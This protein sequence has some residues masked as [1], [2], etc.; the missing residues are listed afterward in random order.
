M[1]TM[2]HNHL[3]CWNDIPE[4]VLINILK[5]LD[6]K[7][8]V[9]CSEVCSDWNRVCEDQLL[10][11][12]LFTRNYGT[13]E[14]KKDTEQQFV[15]KQGAI[16]WK[17]EYVRLKDKVPSVPIQTLTAHTDE[18]LHVAFSHDGTEFISC[19]KDNKIIV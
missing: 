7:E 14:F 2:G 10:W 11:K 9:A 5:Q 18:V 13:K 3:I 1:A 16:C 4:P 8:V 17:D 15:L 19:S 12:H 6:T